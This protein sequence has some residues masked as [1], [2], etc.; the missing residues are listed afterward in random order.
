MPLVA[1][2][3][4]VCAGPM[5][6]PIEQLLGW[7][8]SSGLSVLP[9]LLEFAHFAGKSEVASWF[10]SKQEASQYLNTV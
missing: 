8:L 2:R 3:T 10:T 7:E 4:K 1:G 6:S 9:D 5:N